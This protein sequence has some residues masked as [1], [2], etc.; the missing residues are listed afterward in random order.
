MFF[1]PYPAPTSPTLP[2]YF[3]LGE[4]AAFFAGALAAA[5]G[6]VF[7][8]FGAFG[9]LVGDFAD[10]F[11]FDGDFGAF[12]AAAAAAFPAFFF[13]TAA[14][15]GDFAFFSPAAATA[16]AAAA[17][18]FFLAAAVVPVA[19]AFFGD[20]VRLAAAVVVDFALTT[21]FGFAAP[22]EAAVAAFPDAGAASLNEPL[23]PLPF[24]CTNTPDVT[25]FFK[26]LRMKGDTFSASTL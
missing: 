10:L 18:A 16:A 4:A 11:A 24:V 20:F 25:A 6:L 5:V 8:G 12:A 14:F 2:A 3:F 1:H 23:A 22:S 26:Y 19:T 9:F 17:A 13:S 15:F 7:F 21:F